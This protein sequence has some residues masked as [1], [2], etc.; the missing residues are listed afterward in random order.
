MGLLSGLLGQ[1]PLGELVAGAGEE[2]GNPGALFQLPVTSASLLGLWTGYALS[3][4]HIIIRVNG[5]DQAL[6]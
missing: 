3:K 5:L 4:C 6:L 2:G 1:R